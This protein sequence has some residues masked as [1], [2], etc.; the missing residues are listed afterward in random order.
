VRKITL[1]TQG[2]VTSI[3]FTLLALTGYSEPAKAE[4]PVD[5]AIPEPVAKEPPKPIN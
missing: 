5:T 2:P 4:N 3:L 1:H